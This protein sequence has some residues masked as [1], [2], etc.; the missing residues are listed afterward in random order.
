MPRWSV[1]RGISTI[2]PSAEAPPASAFRMWLLLP[3]RTVSPR[4][5]CASNATR[6]LCVP[7]L[8]ITAASL[9]SISAARSSRR[10]V[11]G[12]SPYTSSPSSAS[13]IALRISGLGWLTVSLRRSTRIIRLPHLTCGI[14]QFLEVYDGIRAY[15]EQL[16]RC[17]QCVA[18]GILAA[19]TVLDSTAS[20]MGHRS[21]SISEKQIAMR[22][23]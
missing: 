14:C 3:I 7:E 10:F 2:P 15:P 4:P 8:T 16:R 12:S 11:V 22:G 17:Y 18:A 21:Q 5:A 13:Y 19:R 9:P 23:H 6:L 1:C 20:D